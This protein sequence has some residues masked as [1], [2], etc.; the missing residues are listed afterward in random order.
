MSKQLIFNL[1][2]TF[3]FLSTSISTPL[4]L[5]TAISSNNTFN[6]L[7][8]RALGSIASAHPELAD[9]EVVDIYDDSA[10]NGTERDY[11][12]T[13]KNGNVSILAAVSFHANLSN[14]FVSFTTLPNSRNNYTG[15]AVNNYRDNETNDSNLENTPP[16]PPPQNAPPPPPNQN[17]AHLLGGYQPLPSLTDARF[18]IAQTYLLSLHPNIINYRLQY[19]E[20]Q[21]ITGINYLMFYSGL[22]KLT[23]LTAKVY[24]DLNGVPYLTAF[25]VTCAVPSSE[26]N[27]KIAG[28]VYNGTEQVLA[29]H[30]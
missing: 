11:F 2:L 16:L 8:I 10:M 24:I 1:L 25:K 30:P 14:F 26:C 13:M 9:Y 19:V 5:L 4:T 6:Q 21:V 18:N 20:Y 12:V 15:P 28:G 7:E 29:V 3:T 22:D 27:S 17:G 23:S